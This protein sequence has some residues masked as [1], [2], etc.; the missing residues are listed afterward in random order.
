MNNAG[1]F[2]RAKEFNVRR[3]MKRLDE[4]KRILRECK[5]E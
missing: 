1:K 5:E 2:T 4:I 3:K